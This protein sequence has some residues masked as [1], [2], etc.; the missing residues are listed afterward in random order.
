MPS[1]GYPNRP[2]HSNH[3]CVGSQLCFQ[4][5][6]HYLKDWRGLR[7][8]LNLSVSCRGRYEG[9]VAL[10][11]VNNLIVC[12]LTAL[13]RCV[14][15]RTWNAHAMDIWCR[16]RAAKCKTSF[17]SWTMLLFAGL[18]SA[19]A[20]PF[21]YHFYFTESHVSCASRLLLRKRQSFLLTGRVILP[22]WQLL[23]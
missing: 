10:D 13:K 21:P 19:Q 4:G 1:Y 17:S 16:F 18:N 6:V 23:L 20:S 2:L 12:C 14:A 22:P 15:V 5:A 11:S 9:I 8:D 7:G 3:N